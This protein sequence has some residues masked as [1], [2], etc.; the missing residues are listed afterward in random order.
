MC[1]T[2][3]RYEKV[4]TVMAGNGDINRL[5]NAGWVIIN[6]QFCM[7][8]RNE[9]GH[10]AR[11]YVLHAFMGLPAN[12]V[13]TKVDNEDLSAIQERFKTLGGS[14]TVNASETLPNAAIVAGQSSPEVQVDTEVIAQE[15]VQD[16]PMENEQPLLGQRRVRQRQPNNFNAPV[17][18][19]QSSEE[20]IGLRR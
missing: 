2:P 10:M 11:E 3:M 7:D 12:A 4:T 13:V 6:S 18:L 16:K 9:G 8:E 17:N 5:L 19:N 20:M 15:V 1:D 14:P